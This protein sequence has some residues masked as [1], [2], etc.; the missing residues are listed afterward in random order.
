MSTKLARIAEKAKSDPRIKFTS[1]A[2]L[3]GPDFLRESW[4]QLNR[5]GAS[6]IDGETI[7]QF[8][9]NLKDRV[10]H[11]ISRLK[12]G[13]YR[14]PP[15][16]Q[17][18]I[19]KVRG[20]RKLGIPAVEDRLLQRAVAR[21]LSAIF[22]NDFLEV[23]FG[24]R[25]GRG[26]HHA[27]R[28]LS[29]AITTKKIRH[30]YETDVAG[31]FTSIDHKW[32]RRMIAERIADPVIISLIGKWLNAGVMVQGVKIRQDSGTPQ[33]GPVSCVLSNV[34]LHYALDLWFERK[35][36]KWC[37]GEAYLIRF[38]DDFVTCFQYKR[39]AERF[40]RYRRKRLA[41]FGLRTAPEKTK[42]LKFGRFARADSEEYSEKPET[43]DF[44]GFKHVCGRDRKGEF[45]L[46]RIPSHR[47]CRKFLDTTEIWLRKHSHWKRRDQQKQLSQM[48]RGFYQYFSL[49]HCDPKL[50]WILSEVKL[51]WIR[52]LRRRSQRHRLYWSYLSNSDWFK[53]PY[54]PR[55]VHPMI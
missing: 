49:H 22:E 37:Q 50:Q 25:P 41:K 35:F 39:D 11:L 27:L 33:G 19:P 45:S 7:E 6:G 46:I 40:D 32:I 13:T 3:L 48:L 4:K 21:I 52:K 23:S 17:V 42:L 47:S 55:T 26:P 43:F 2:H 28:E 51:Q 54:P 1:L 44:L 15:V 30:I 36:K 8:E 14:A 31:Y 16:K 38:V 12:S 29:R 9:S 20:T 18:E 24:Y 53:L 34:Y 10:D 5:K